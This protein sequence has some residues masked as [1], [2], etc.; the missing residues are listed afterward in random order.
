MTLPKPTPRARSPAMPISSSLSVPLARARPPHLRPA[1]EHLRA[2]SHAVFGVAPSATGAEVLSEETGVAAD[3]IHKLLIKHTLSRPPDHRYDLP[4]GATVIVNEAGMLPTEK[5]AEMAHLADIRGWRLRARRRP[6]SVPA[7]GHGG[8]YA[9]MVNTFAAIELDEVH[10]SPNKWEREASLRLRRGDVVRRVR[11]PRPPARRRHCRRWST[12][13]APLAP[14]PPGRRAELLMTPTNE[15]T[16]RLNERCQR[17]RIRAGK[18]DAD[19]RSVDVGAYQLYVGTRSPRDRTT[20]TPH[21]PRRHG[22]QPSRLDDRR[23]PPRRLPDRDRQV[24]V[25]VHLPAEYVNEHVELA[26]ARTGMGGQGRNVLGGL[27]FADRLTDIRNLYVAMTRLGDRP[28]LL[29]VTGEETAVNI[30]LQCM[31]T[32]WIDQPATV[33]HAN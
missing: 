28:H 7:V 11:R 6:A 15:A 9:L 12:P 13:P 18:I 3:T 31:T 8:M 4:V 17:L 5:L 16:E 32:D 30:F 1:V 2:N 14:T 10:R 21:R 24:R 27:L 25:L 23:H 26:Y 29:G 20:S 19:G 22:P 33:R